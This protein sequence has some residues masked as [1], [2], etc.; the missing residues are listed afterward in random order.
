MSI[1]NIKQ[2]KKTA[3]NS[4]ILAGDLLLKKFKGFDRSQVKYKAKHE[5]VTAADLASEKKIISQV[6]K[7][8]PD[9]QI[10][11]EEGGA[12]GVT[13]DYLW[14]IDPLDGTTNFSMH[15]PL[16]SVSIGVVYKNILQL[17][18]IY[19]PYL[20]ELYVAEVGKGAFIQSPETGKRKRMEI[21]TKKDKEALYAFC[22]GYNKKD[23][24][25]ALKYYKYQKLNK[26]DCRQLGSAAIELSYVACGRIDSIV[27]PG[28]NSWDVAAGVLMVREAGGRVTNFHNK[29]WTLKSEDMAASN[30]KVHKNLMEAINMSGGMKS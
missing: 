22:H 4:A 15:N 9:H 11:S 21:S 20:K 19:A 10:L 1:T 17:G 30:R 27:I 2:I 23:I 26:I 8:F 25:K 14:I 28:A 13:S 3:I 16:W 6:K 12:S 7:T 29:S 24:Q 18:V 5:I